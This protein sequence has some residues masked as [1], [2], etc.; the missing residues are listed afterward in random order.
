MS[1]ARHT[2][3]DIAE[4]VVAARRAGNASATLHGVK[5]DLT[6]IG[7]CSKFVRQAHEAALGHSMSTNDGGPCACCAA[8]T[9]V[10]LRGEG[11][12]LGQPDRGAIVCFNHPPQ[13]KKCKWCGRRVGHIGICLGNDLIAENTSANNRGDPRAAGT[14][15]SPL[16]SIGPSRVSGY[17]SSIKA[18]FSY[19][20]GPITIKLLEV[21]HDGFLRSGVAYLPARAL[22]TLGFAVT[23][24]ILDQGT[25]YIY[26]R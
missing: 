19:A 10:N 21:P 15:I 14:K 5:F 13:G 9:E 4:Q 26:R 6:E 25:V 17:Y 23:D 16:A 8:A 3:A 11:F 7:W 22:T 12:A 2:V 20:D 24:H 18:Q 1:V